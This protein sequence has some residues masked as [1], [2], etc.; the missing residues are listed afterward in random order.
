MTENKMNMPT[1][2]TNP[3]STTPD[4]TE[5]ECHENLWKL[6]R[7]GSTIDYDQV[8]NDPDL[9]ERY[10]EQITSMLYDGRATGRSFEELFPQMWLNSYR[11]TDESY[12]E[13]R[14]RALPGLWPSEQAPHN[15]QMFDFYPRKSKDGYL[16]LPTFSA[17]AQVF[18]VRNQL[19]PLAMGTLRGYLRHYVSGMASDC[20]T[21]ERN[22]STYQRIEACL[23]ILD[24]IQP[25]DYVMWLFRNDEDE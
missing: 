11:E 21:E 19:L 17:A 6:M 20:Y 18:F 24:S 22:S 3:N 8:I 23:Q 13:P 16:P 7:L 1:N 10:V 25:G 12:H 2:A 15:W 9:I 5:T 4:I 14:Q